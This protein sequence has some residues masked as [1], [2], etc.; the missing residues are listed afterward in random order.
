MCVNG[1]G[2]RTAEGG[3]TVNPRTTFTLSYDLDHS[4]EGGMLSER[5]GESG[6]N[7]G[8]LSPHV[9][10]PRFFQQ[11][12]LIYLVLRCKLFPASVVDPKDEWI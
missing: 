8:T 5:E 2:I 9:L 10:R 12:T 1:G 7:K 6:Q 11:F 3:E 4:G